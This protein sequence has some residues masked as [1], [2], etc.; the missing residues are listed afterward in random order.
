MESIIVDGRAR[1]FLLHL[2]PEPEGRPLIIALHA[3]GSNPLLMEAMTDFSSMADREGFIVAY[4]EG[5]RSSDAGFRSWNA[6]FCCRDAK[7]EGVDDIG[8]LSA[9]IDQMGARYRIKGVLITG[10]SN[11]GML[12]HLAGIELADE[13]TAIAPVAA[14]VGQEVVEQTPKRT[15]PVLMV[16]GDSDRLLPFDERHD[17]RF[18]PASQVVQ[19]WV[20]ENR[21]APRPEV[22]ETPELIIERYRPLDDGAEVILYRLKNAGHLWPG[23]RVHL[24]TEHDPHTLGASFLIWTF[25]RSHL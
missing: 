15:L 5:F 9:L 22:E 23:S 20:R 16:H 6:R 19:Y 2:P 25:F 13:I 18:L 21:C 1:S 8:F 7:G 3:L 14:T 17:D 10:F 4:P 24:R 12:A 11:G